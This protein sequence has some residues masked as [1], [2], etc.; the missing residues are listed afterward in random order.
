M[1]EEMGGDGDCKY[2]EED[3]IS[4]LEAPWINVMLKKMIRIQKYNFNIV[5]IDK[6]TE[7]KIRY[8]K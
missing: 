3:V 8:G 7:G 5:Y 4:T 6:K 1:G 2:G